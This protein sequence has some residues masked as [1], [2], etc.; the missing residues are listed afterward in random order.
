VSPWPDLPEDWLEQWLF[1][2]LTVYSDRHPEV[3]N[4]ITCKA[5]VFLPGEPED[6]TRPEP[7]NAAYQDFPRP[8]PI[9]QMDWRNLSPLLVVEVVSS[10]PDKDLVRN[11]DLYLRMP[12]IKEYWI[13][14]PREDADHPTLL[15]N[16]RRGSRWQRPITMHAGGTCTT[17]LLPDFALLV[18]PHA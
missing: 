8:I 11:V 1:R 15:V 4:H 14:D 18:D 7:D 10:D 13:L 5:R 16:R 12:S 2:P 6:V 3:I 17:K 9:A